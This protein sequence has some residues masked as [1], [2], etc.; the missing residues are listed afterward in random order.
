[1][2]TINPLIYSTRIDKIDDPNKGTTTTISVQSIANIEASRLESRMIVLESVDDFIRNIESNTKADLVITVS[3][4]DQS[5][6]D[7]HTVFNCF[8]SHA[9]IHNTIKKELEYMNS[10][11]HIEIKRK[12]GRRPTKHRIGFVYKNRI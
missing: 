11:N 1:M 12:R 10:L 9:T 8:G 6:E 5:N 2:K 4:S 7:G 3:C